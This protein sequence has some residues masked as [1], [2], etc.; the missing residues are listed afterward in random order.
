LIQMYRTTW[1]GEDTIDVYNTP[2]A[3]GAA[4][5]LLNW[6]T[7][8]ANVTSQSGVSFLARVRSLNCDLSDQIELLRDDPDRVQRQFAI[9]QW[10]DIEK[11]L[12]V[13]WGAADT[14]ITTF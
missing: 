5:F 2:Y 14:S 9:Q 11:L 13:G 6:P 7:T 10:R 3:P 12:V 1:F 8:D 4:K